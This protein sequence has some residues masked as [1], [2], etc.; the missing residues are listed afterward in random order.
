[1][2]TLKGMI[3][4]TDIWSDT[5]SDGKKWHL[6]KIWIRDTDTGKIYNCQLNENDPQYKDFIEVKGDEHTPSQ[7]LAYHAITVTIIDAILSKSLKDPIRCVANYQIT[8]IRD[9]S[10]PKYDIE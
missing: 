8:N 9:L 10:P 1:M 7:S 2:L 3:E 5:Y 6:F 4:R